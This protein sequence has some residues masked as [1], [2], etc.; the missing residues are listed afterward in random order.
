MADVLSLPAVEVY[1]E[2]SAEPVVPNLDPPVASETDRLEELA[3]RHG[4]NYDAYLVTEPGW[5]YFWSRGR[6]GVVA[7]ARQGRYLFSSG[8][9]LAPAEH[10]AEL[11]EQLVDRAERD[12]LV[13]SFFNIAE[14]QLALFRSFGFQATKW[15]EEA[16]VDLPGRT[17]SGK[18]FE[19]VRRQ[20]N[21]CRRHGLAMSECVREAVSPARWERLIADVSEVSRLFLESKPQSTEM[22][23]LQGGFDPQQ[24][25]RKRV[26]IARADQGAGRIEG[27]LACN[28]CDDGRTW[29][30]ETFRQRPDAV[31]GTI[32]FLMHQVMQHLKEEGVERVS[33]CLIPGLGCRESLPGDSAM[34]RWGL[35]IGTQKFNLVFDTAG[36]YH[37]K[38]R[39]RPRF[40]SRYLCVR[41][42]MSF[43][44]AMAFIRLLGVLKVDFAKMIQLAVRRWQKRVSRATLW[45]P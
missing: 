7:V 3:V 24:L 33:L 28:P 40:E 38:S 17:W 9:L 37:F 23:F 44:V 15:G 2:M 43:G 4:R 31:R 18:S 29:V 5:E 42:K 34:A 32:P 36:A 41:P 12:R 8:G 25:G 6:R 21:F 19:W 45:T 27:F 39:F 11:L 26:F 22:R 35:V 16:L 30:M 14:N 13:L 20:T 10:Q 1:R